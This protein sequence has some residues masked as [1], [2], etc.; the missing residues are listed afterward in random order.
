LFHGEVVS[1]SS[2]VFIVGLWVFTVTASS[3]CHCVVDAVVVVVTVCGVVWM[4]GHGF[5]RQ[6]FG[7]RMLCGRELFKGEVGVVVVVGVLSE[8]V[9][10]CWVDF[11]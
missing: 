6:G 8:E 3:E 9:G 2:S 10:A 1:W 5:F 11:H 7:V 4:D